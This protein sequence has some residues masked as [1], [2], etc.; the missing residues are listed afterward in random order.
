MCK[1]KNKCICFSSGVA[2]FSAIGSI[3]LFVLYISSKTIVR[4]II[5]SC[6]FITKAKQNSV[7]GHS[8]N[9]IGHTRTV[10]HFFAAVIALLQLLENKTFL[11]LYLKQVMTL[12]RGF[13]LQLILGGQSILKEVLHSLI[14]LRQNT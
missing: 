10:W 7:H 1:H 12:L 13:L 11:G 4:C 14:A 3:Y 5:D 9:I 2:M 6:N 8:T